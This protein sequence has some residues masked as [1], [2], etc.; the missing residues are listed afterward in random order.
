MERSSTYIVTYHV[1]N[2]L[3]AN[4]K[5]NPKQKERVKKIKLAEKITLNKNGAGM[6]E[7]DVPKR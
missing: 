7:T 4:E 2:I 1:N 5:K 6:S 3:F